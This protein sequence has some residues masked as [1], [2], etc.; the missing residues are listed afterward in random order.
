MDHKFVK[1]VESYREPNENEF[2]FRED[3]FNGY[4]MRQLFDYLEEEHGIKIQKIP[5]WQLKSLVQDSYTNTYT[6]ISYGV[7][8]I[9]NDT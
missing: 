4:G 3:P 7:R 6:K 1:V 2:F 9:K 5:G 8:V